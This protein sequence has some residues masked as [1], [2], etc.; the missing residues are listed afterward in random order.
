NFGRSVSKNYGHLSQQNCNFFLSERF[1]LAAFFTLLRLF[2]SGKR[3]E[4]ISTVIALTARLN[5]T[6]KVLLCLN[7]GKVIPARPR[8]PVIDD[9]VRPYV[10]GIELRTARHELLKQIQLRPQLVDRLRTEI[11]AFFATEE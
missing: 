6:A 1:G 5:E 11:L 9:I 2:D 4:Q 7:L 10:A 8:C 3:V